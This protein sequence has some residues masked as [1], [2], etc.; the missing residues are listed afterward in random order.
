[1]QRERTVL[2][3]GVQTEIKMRLAIML[4]LYH[5]RTYMYMHLY[6]Y[7]YMKFSLHTFGSGIA[8]TY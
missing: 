6:L 2:F 4:T 3:W 5:Y 1:M 7:L 8:H